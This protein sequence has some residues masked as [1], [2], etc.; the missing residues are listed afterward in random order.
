[1]S[2][3]EQYEY[4]LQSGFIQEV[5]IPNYFLIVGSIQ[6]LIKEHGWRVAPSLEYGWSILTKSR[7][8]YS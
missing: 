1:M 6:N 4:M 3:L 8:F 7:L 2:T 5:S